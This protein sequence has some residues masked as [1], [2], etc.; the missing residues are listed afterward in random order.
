MKRSDAKA[1]KCRLKFSSEISL[2]FISLH[3]DLALDINWYFYFV[4]NWPSKKL[5]TKWNQW[6]LKRL[7]MC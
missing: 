7:E 3:L 5:T 2:F 4:V 1:S 6:V